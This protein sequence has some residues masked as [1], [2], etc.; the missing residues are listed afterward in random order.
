[1]R[2]VVLICALFS[3]LPCAYAM[4][5]SKPLVEVDGDQ[6]LYE[7]YVLCEGS[8]E[9]ERIHY[10]GIAPADGPVSRDVMVSVMAKRM[11][12]YQKTLRGTVC[13]TV[14]RR[15]RGL[16]L[17]YTVHFSKTGYEIAFDYKSNG[18]RF[19]ERHSW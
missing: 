7:R 9:S 5:P 4:D 3:L 2:V 13:R 16:D 6:W 8:G 19:S 14:S 17:I 18:T 11:A 1:M 12:D 10:R 15:T